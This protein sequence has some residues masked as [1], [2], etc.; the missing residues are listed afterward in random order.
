LIIALAEPF[1]RAN[2]DELAP[3]NHP[4]TETPKLMTQTKCD[5]EETLRRRILR[6][7]NNI[8]EL[9]RS[10]GNPPP[11]IDGVIENSQRHGY[12]L[13]PDRVRVVAVSE[14]PRG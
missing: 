13:N 1:R 12:R 8:A 10:A 3:E 4:Y 6:C 5:T 7:R 9:A 11:S 14:L 2:R